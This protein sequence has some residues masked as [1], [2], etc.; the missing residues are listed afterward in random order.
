MINDIIDA[1]S[2]INNRKAIFYLDLSYVL[3]ND[4][5]SG[6]SLNQIKSVLKK[7]FPLDDYN[8]NELENLMGENK[9]AT[10]IAFYLDIETQG[11]WGLSSSNNIT[12][13]SLRQEMIQIFQ[14]A[15]IKTESIECYDIL[16]IDTHILNQI[17]PWEDVIQFLN[18]YA[19]HE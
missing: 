10:Y 9:D 6:K 11:I 19:S 16:E 12:V 4:V 14:A 2:K 18:K 15:G 5:I 17:V 13:E 1:F 3:H 7:C 8:Y